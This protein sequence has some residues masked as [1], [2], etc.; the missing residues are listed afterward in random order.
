MWLSTSF[1]NE[2][3]LNE[4]ENLMKIPL[5]CS[6]WSL[7]WYGS[8]LIDLNNRYVTIPSHILIYNTGPRWMTM[9]NLASLNKLNGIEMV[10]EKM[11]V[12]FMTP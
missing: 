4:I 12:Q 3:Y 5:I 8:Q 1:R 9:N 7:E 2:K 6:I 10:M 11:H